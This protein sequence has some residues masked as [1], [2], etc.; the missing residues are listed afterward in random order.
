LNLRAQIIRDGGE[1]LEHVDALLRL[2]RCHT[3]HVPAKVPRAF[4]P[5]ELR[6]AVFAE[7][8]NGA[9]G[10]LAAGGGAPSMAAAD[11]NGGRLWARR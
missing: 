1:G 4:R 9:A 5:G 10:R 8:Y 2:R 7:T 3:E 6:R 11:A